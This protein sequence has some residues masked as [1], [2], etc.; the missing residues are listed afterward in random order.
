MALSCVTIPPLDAIIELSFRHG[1]RP[2]MKFKIGALKFQHDHEIIFIRNSILAAIG[3]TAA[4]KSVLAAG[5]LAS[6]GAA[7]VYNRARRRAAARA[8]DGRVSDSVTDLD[9]LMLYPARRRKLMHKIK[10]A[11]VPWAS[12]CRRKRKRGRGPPGEKRRCVVCRRII[13]L[14]PRLCNCFLPTDPY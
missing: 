5:M 7:G 10:C 4:G 8:R 9:A 12:A 11:Y 1:N 13:L 2:K 6:L 14:A 3:L